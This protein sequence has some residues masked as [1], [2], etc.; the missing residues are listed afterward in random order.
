MAKRNEKTLNGKT[1][2]NSEVI[3]HK[4]D[5]KTV[6]ETINMQADEVLQTINKLEKSQQVTMKTLMLEFKL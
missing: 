4:Y 3:L 2:N 6:N 5:K 1:A